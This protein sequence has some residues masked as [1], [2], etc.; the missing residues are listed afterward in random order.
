MCQFNYGL[1]VSPQALGPFFPV[2]RQWFDAHHSPHPRWTPA[3]ST[4]AS[5]TAGRRSI[6]IGVKSGR[7]LRPEMLT[8][9]QALEQA[10][11]F[12][13]AEQEEG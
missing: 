10:R 5:R 6:F 4:F 11:A 3:A 9:E 12:A 7:R 1:G 2:S 8:S 13:R